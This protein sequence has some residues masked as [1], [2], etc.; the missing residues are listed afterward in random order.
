[1]SDSP[2]AA[3]RLRSGDLIVEVDGSAVSRA[4][5]LQRLMVEGR[6]GSKLAI[7]IIREDRLVAL[8]VV[9]AELK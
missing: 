9:P 3:A 6:I 7:R 8:E 1:M 2:A 5:D 4:G